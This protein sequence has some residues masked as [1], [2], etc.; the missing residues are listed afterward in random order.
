MVNGKETTIPLELERLLTILDKSGQMNI[1]ALVRGGGHHGQITAICLG[2][3]RAFVE[4]NPDYKSTLRKAG[5]LTVD[6]RVKERKKPGLK[7]ARR[8][9]QWAKR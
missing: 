2:V 5:Y 6:A 8:A 4:L 1:S 7:R 3:A 9:P